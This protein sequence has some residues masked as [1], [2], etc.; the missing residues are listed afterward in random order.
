MYMMPC[1]MLE[2]M[3]RI[4]AERGDSIVFIVS[5]KVYVYRGSNYLLPNL[6]KLAPHRGNL[7]Q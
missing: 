7:E 6:M 1:Q 5:G 4:V 3:E 2:D